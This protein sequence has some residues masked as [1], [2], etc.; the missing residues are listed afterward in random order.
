MRTLLLLLASILGITTSA[1]IASSTISS[2][3]VYDIP[4]TA[5]TAEANLIDESDLDYFA[6][7]GLIGIRDFTGE[8]WLSVDTYSWWTY[9]RSGDDFNI[10]ITND[11]EDN[12]QYYDWTLQNDTL[13]RLGVEV[14]HQ[15]SGDLYVDYDD[16]NYIHLIYPVSGGQTWQFSPYNPN[17]IEEYNKEVV[18]IVN[19][20][21]MPF[22]TFYDVICV[23]TES[24]SE[25]SS[26][27][28]AYY[29]QENPFRAICGFWHTDF[30]PEGYYTINSSFP[31]QATSVE[32]QASSNIK[33][34]P[35]PATNYVSLDIN[36]GEQF[37]VLNSQG[38]VVMDG[39]YEGR[40]QTADLQQG[41]Y[42][43]RTNSQSVKFI[44]Q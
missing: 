3:N 38:Q 41:I 44:K 19:E 21:I 35:N 29:E 26:D 24:Q 43:I 15:E 2:M 14:A 13:L 27:G 36:L 11:Q 8:S 12:I 5:S 32:E 20:L 6:Q 34:F 22:G 39:R 9:E 7:G 42:S 40:I 28:Y 30:Q 16:P 18:G 37:W 23:K 17:G 33:L 1:Q 31:L 10:T 25:F 4:M